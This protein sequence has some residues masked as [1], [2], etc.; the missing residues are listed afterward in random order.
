MKH[1]WRYNTAI[2]SN[3]SI[4]R[5]D[6]FSSSANLSS[7]ISS[8]SNKPRSK[9]RKKKKKKCK[10]KTAKNRNKSRSNAVEPE[11]EDAL[12]VITS[13]RSSKN[14]LDFPIREI[15]GDSDDSDDEA[16][17]FDQNDNEQDLETGKEVFVSKFQEESS[18]SSSIQIRFSDDHNILLNNSNNYDRLKR[19]QTSIETKIKSLY[20]N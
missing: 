5:L 10:K 13:S 12:V 20:L 16:D 7:I 2:K 1:S 6:S 8:K 11:N 3:R 15:P 14:D 19:P 18:R 17:D 9:S 4:F